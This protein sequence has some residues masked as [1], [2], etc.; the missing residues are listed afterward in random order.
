MPNKTPEQLNDRVDMLQKKLVGLGDD[1]DVLKL[2]RLKKSIR[3]TQ[4]KSKRV[5]TALDR[6]AGKPKETAPEG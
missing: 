4:R 2:R 6:A 1:S 5:A 3:R